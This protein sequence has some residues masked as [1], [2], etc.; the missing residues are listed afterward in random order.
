MFLVH[1]D[2]TVHVQYFYYANV[3]IS[4]RQDNAFFV[5]ILSTQFICYNLNDYILVKIKLIDII[6]IKTKM[7]KLQ[8]QL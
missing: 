7:T 8:F 5:E 4:N 6:E 3:H 1:F 2:D